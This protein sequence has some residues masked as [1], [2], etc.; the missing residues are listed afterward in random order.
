MFMR[1]NIFNKA[2]LPLKKA[3][4]TGCISIADIMEQESIAT[5]SFTWLVS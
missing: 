5:Y 3:L 4:L 2:H 1:Y